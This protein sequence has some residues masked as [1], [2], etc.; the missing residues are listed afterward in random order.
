MTTPRSSP[1]TSV[2]YAEKSPWR[3]AARG[4]VVAVAVLLVLVVV[5]YATLYVYGLVS[6]T[7]VPV[8]ELE[9]ADDGADNTLL[10]VTDQGAVAGMA[11]VQVSDQR[12]TPA[13]LLLP[14]D[15]RVQAEGQ[16][17]RRLAAFHE[18]GG[19][20]LL[21]DAVQDFTSIP[22]DHY[23]TVSVDGLA[24]L[25]D[26]LGGI[27]LC[28]E[29]GADGCRIAVAAEVAE[30]FRPVGGDADDDPARVAELD[31]ILRNA[32]YGA[33]RTSVLLNPLRAKRLVDLYASAVSSD[34]DLG[35]RGL[36][37]MAES[38]AA[39]P[40]DA[41][42]VRVVPGVRQGEEV[43][44]TMGRAV[45][46]FEAFRQVGPLPDAGLEAP[47]ELT[48]ADVT[49]RVLN[50]VGAAGLAADMAGFL[51]GKG[52]VI[53]STDNARLFDRN[54][55]TRIVYGEGGRD[56]AVLVAGFVPEAGEIE[57]GQ[58]PDGVDV[59]IT[60]GSDWSRS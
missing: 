6:V 23:L 28:R 41:L 29:P 32:V 15:L 8:A 14:L 18:D 46:L 56:K 7:G 34:R 3:S 11:V 37:Q 24:R 22:L 36:R 10:V 58:V 16:G 13:V 55:P 48:P 54:A 21:V 53:E 31:T 19:I 39:V 40:G 57:E 20:A 49:V 43:R 44:A 9:R 17:T 38:I 2:R 26:L 50:G 51:E 45:T 59:V 12:R 4:G 1:F 27:P 47:R 42:Q 52:F 35:P 5:L 30:A 33:T 25:A 60:V